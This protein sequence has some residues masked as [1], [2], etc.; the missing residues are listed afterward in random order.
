VILSLKIVSLGGDQGC[1]MF[2]RSTSLYELLRQIAGGLRYYVN[3]R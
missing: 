3:I 2:D 1:P